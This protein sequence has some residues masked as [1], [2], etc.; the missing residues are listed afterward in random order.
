ML[1]EIILYKDINLQD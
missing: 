1:K